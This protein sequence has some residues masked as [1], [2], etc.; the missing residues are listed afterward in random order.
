M[1]VTSQI[2]DTRSIYGLENTKKINK[3]TKQKQQLTK[4]LVEA[5][6]Q[7]SMSINV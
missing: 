4:P 1:L 2:K 3:Q 5:F 7:Q 6:A